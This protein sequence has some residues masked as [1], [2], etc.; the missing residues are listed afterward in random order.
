M[1]KTEKY[2]F[3]D[4]YAK[5]ADEI[6][7]M[8]LKFKDKMISQLEVFRFSD[9]LVEKKRD[10]F[11]S[12]LVSD[13]KFKASNV[14]DE[15]NSSTLDREMEDFLSLAVKSFE[16]IEEFNKNEYTITIPVV[17]RLKKQAS[18]IIKKIY[19]L[20]GYV[21]YVNEELLKDMKFDDIIVVD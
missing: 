19:D 4:F 15:I 10:A 9:E 11:V 12:T 14:Y 17:N 5:E 13:C 8:M 6:S 18:N 1:K 3:R 2:N 21:N 20:S 7:S 16:L